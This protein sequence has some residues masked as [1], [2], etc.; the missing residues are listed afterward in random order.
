MAQSG[1]V[2]QV[3]FTPYGVPTLYRGTMYRTHTRNAKHRRHGVL[4][5]FIHFELSTVL[6]FNLE[7]YV[8]G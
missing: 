8:N 1:N 7:G 6:G 5:P 4:F 3:R 2:S